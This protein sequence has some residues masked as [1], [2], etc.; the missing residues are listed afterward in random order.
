MRD[1]RNQVSS[2]SRPVVALVASSLLAI[3]VFLV[4]APRPASL[5]RL[6]LQLA[7]RTMEDGRNTLFGP[8]YLD[9]KRLTS[10]I[11]ESA[12]VDLVL[13]RPKAR[14]LAVLAGSTLQPRR[15]TENQPHRNV[16][17]LHHALDHGALLCI[18]PAKCGDVGPHDV[19]QLRH[20]GSRTVVW[21]GLRTPSSGFDTP[22]TEIVVEAPGGYI[23]S[24]GGR[25]SRS[26]P[27]ASSIAASPS[28]L[29]G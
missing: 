9:A 14:N 22:P 16:E 10:T 11:P 28:S 3:S 1:A 21:P 26:T 25:K 8:W 29:R 23:T 19:E 12:L 4:G 17:V 27:S 20:H 2:S 5:V 15:F 6:G 7:P 24:T 13:A 18:L